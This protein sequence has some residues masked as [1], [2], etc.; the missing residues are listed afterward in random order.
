MTQLIR[1][2]IRSWSKLLMLATVAIYALS[3]DVTVLAQ[4]D[5]GGHWVGTWAT[6]T[7]ER[8]PQP[9]DD[10]FGR[11]VTEPA[12]NFNGQ[13]LR[14]IVRTST[15]GSRVRVTVS[16]TFGTTPL[17]I[18]GASIAQRDKDATIVVGSALALTFDGEPDITIPAGAYVLSDPADLAVSAVSDLAIDLYLP[19]DTAAGTSP[20]TMHTVAAQTNYVSTSGNHVGVADLPVMTT[21]LSWFFLARVEVMAPRSVGAVVAFGDSI[22]DGTRSTPDTNNR[23]PNHLTKRFMENGIEMGVLNT[24]IAANRVLGEWRGVNALARFDRDVLTQSAVTDV[25]VME[26]INDLRV[27]PSVTAGDM[28]WG[29][30]QL[31]ARAHARGLR[32]YGATLLPCEDSGRW[33]PEVESKRQEINDWIRTSDAYDGVIDF[34][35][36]VRDPDTPSKLLPEYDSSD[37]LHPSDA[38]YEA[39]AAAVPLEFFRR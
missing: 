3:A 18:G 19:G 27:D 15:G 25:V 35:A 2:G 22:T 37:H 39:M 6:A 17:S 34:D 38:G 9:T 13:T 16:N 30:R 36:A 10:G 1:N 28:I 14:Q 7:V 4:S 31:I 5:N 12:L 26:G 21:T 11:A 33:T 23:W 20:L 32:I 29:Y 8:E 24:G